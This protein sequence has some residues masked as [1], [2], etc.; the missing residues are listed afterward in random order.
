VPQIVAQA[1]LSPVIGQIHGTEDH[2]TVARALVGSA[3]HLVARADGMRER[4]AAAAKAL[5]VAAKDRLERA[6]EA[7]RTLIERPAPAYQD[8]FLQ[9]RCRE[10]LFRLDERHGDLSLRDKPAEYQRR[11]QEVRAPF[12]AITARDVAAGQGSETLGTWGRAAQT[13]LEHFRW[14]NLH[15]NYNTKQPLESIKWGRQAPKR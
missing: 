3:E 15:G 12:V 9:G 10:L 2:G 6:L 7:L 4:D 8:L 5:D 1:E 11:E 14:M 13:A